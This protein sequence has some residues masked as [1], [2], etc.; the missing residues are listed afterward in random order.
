MKLSIIIPAYNVES[1]LEQ[2]INSCENQDISHD[3]YEIIIIDDGSKDNTLRVAECLA[4]KY[5]NIIV[6]TQVNKGQ[7]VAR[8]HGLD[9]AN[10]EY[11]MFVD[12][13]DYLVENKLNHYLKI[14]EYSDIDTL[15]FRFK[16]EDSDGNF[17]DERMKNLD[18]NKLYTGEEALLK[19]MVFASVCG[20]IYRL[21]LFN[22]NNLRFLA[23]IKH[24]DVEMCFRL[25][26]LIKKYITLNDFAYY[27][28]YNQVSTD[29][30]QNIENIKRGLWSDVIIAANVL[31]MANS[32]QYSLTIQD[33]YIR[34][35]NSMLVSFFLS[36][37]K[38]KI[39]NY[40][41]LSLKLIE[42]KAMGCYPIKGKSNS[43]KSFIFSKLL[44][45][46]IFLKFLFFS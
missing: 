13:D 31:N 12:A 1:Y 17:S 23:G 36:V 18:F 4:R 30:N 29:R 3:D 28:R 26:P 38:D 37:R 9:I 2:C 41:E 33:R 40:N 20:K 14:M 16:V 34:I 46:D 7:A 19:S 22:G 39:W 8:N 10:G 42:L 15:E 35:A 45:C 11:V 32:N 21:R 25:Y 5:N 43:W 27:Y 24:E 6:R 44:N